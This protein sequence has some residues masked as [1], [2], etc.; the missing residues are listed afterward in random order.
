M[1][2]AIQS[3]L[4]FLV[5]VIFG[6][7]CFVILLRIVLQLVQA[8]FYNPLSQFVMKLTDFAVKPLRKILPNPRRIDLASCLLLYV[9]T[10][11]KLFLVIII[12]TSAKAFP[13]PLGLLVLAVPDIL[14]QI[15]DLMFYA[16]LIMVVLSWVAPQ[17]Q[18]P[19]IDVVY[20]ITEPML[21]PA[22]K[23]IPPIAGFD[24]SPI[25][26]MVVIQLVKILLVSPLFSLGT[27]LL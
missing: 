12:T 9:V 24:L 8:S 5:N 4:L 2:S 26:V 25:L 1:G 23:I 10:I 3:A 6:L 15:M 16:I 22:R 14:S 18:N 7:Y 19:I 27:T 21:A 20:S 11:I 17:T 13:N